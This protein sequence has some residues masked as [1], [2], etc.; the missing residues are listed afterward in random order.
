MRIIEIVCC[1]LLITSI[2]IMGTVGIESGEKDIGELCTFPVSGID[3]SGV[4]VEIE[5]EPQKIVTLAPSAAQTMW[6]I[7]GKN[8]VVGITH[9]AEYLEGADEKV[10]ISSSEGEIILESVVSLN[11]DL[12]LAPSIIPG[13]TVEK[14]RETGM[15]VYYSSELR[16][17]ED[18]IEETRLIG[19]LSGECKGAEEVT[20]WMQ[21]SLD[22]IYEGTKG[23]EKPIVLYVFYG[24]TAGEETLI[25]E[26]IEKSGAKNS[27]KLMGISGY[28]QLNAELIVQNE[29]EWIII[30]SDEIEE[31]KNNEIIQKTA[32][33]QMDQIVVVQV[34]HLNQP[35]PRIIL[36]IEKIAY[37]ISQEPE[38][39]YSKLE[40]GLEVGQELE[41][42]RGYFFIAS[43]IFG[44]VGLIIVIGIA[45]RWAKGKW[46]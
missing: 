1:C 45:I 34:E 35:A 21:S 44:Y 20:T 42:Y 8:K 40:T 16:T 28:R 43:Q 37:G 13:K 12:V 38:A 5:K 4:L 17:I 6:E 3:A 30:N 41:S 18:I 27:A 33:A 23:K 14:L 24:W 46:K 11:P 36:A 15:V 22:R 2:L 26:V 39:E 7:G 32:A 31:I 10:V 29:P 25:D 19:K 9:Y